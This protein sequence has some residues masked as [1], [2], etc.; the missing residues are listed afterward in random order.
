MTW[1]WRIALG[2]LMVVLAGAGGG[3][4]WLR[5]SLPDTNGSLALAGLSAPVVVSRDR[6][7]ISTIRAGSELDAYQVLGFVHAQ[8]RLWQMDLQR[9]LGAG[10]L[11]EVLGRRALATDRIMCRS[12][13][14][15]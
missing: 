3:Y 7:A 15:R 6:F 13:I 14:R 12:T 8:D 2:L 11:A 10:R 1:L 9:R 4:L 5:T